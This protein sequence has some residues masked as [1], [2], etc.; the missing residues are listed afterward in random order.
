MQNGGVPMPAAPTDDGAA[1]TLLALFLQVHQQ[2]RD[3]LG[4]VDEEALNWVPTS[5]AN[6]IATIITHLVGSEA[7]ALRSEVWRAEPRSNVTLALRTSGT[8]QS[9]SRRPRR[10]HVDS[11]VLQGVS[12]GWPSVLS[13]LKTLLGT[14]ATLWTS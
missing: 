5:G 9:N 8:G 11:A 2:L 4:G 6:S 7:E 3:E 13:G 10:V 12:E 1:A 14:D